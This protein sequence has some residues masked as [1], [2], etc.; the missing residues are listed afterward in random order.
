[1]SFFDSVDGT[2]AFATWKI[3]L[4][5]PFSSIFNPHASNNEAPDLMLVGEW[6]LNGHPFIADFLK[7]TEGG[8][9]TTVTLASGYA[10]A[11]GT[12]CPIGT[13]GSETSETSNSLKWVTKALKVT[14]AF[15]PADGTPEGISYLPDT[16]S[17]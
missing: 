14:F 1:V 2:D 16:E 9:A 12:Q 17:C 4:G 3:S 5:N 15:T 8:L 13:D 6:S 10:L 11:P 7:G